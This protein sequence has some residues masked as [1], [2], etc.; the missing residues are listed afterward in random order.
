MNTTI[1]LKEKTLEEVKA[2]GA[3]GDSWDDA[4]QKLLNKAK[5]ANSKTEDTQFKGFKEASVDKYGKAM[6]SRTLAGKII[7][8]REK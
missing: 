6:I 5:I 7:E 8:W 4:I 2:Y 3:M 1:K